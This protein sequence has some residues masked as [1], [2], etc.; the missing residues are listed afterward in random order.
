MLCGDLCRAQLLTSFSHRFLTKQRG[1]FVTLCQQLS[2]IR[3]ALLLP[4]CQLALGF[5]LVFLQQLKAL[6]QSRRFLLRTLLF[7]LQGIQ[8]ILRKLYGFGE[9]FVLQQK[10]LSG[11]L[12][13]IASLQPG[14]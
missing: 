13:T 11:L 14:G 1:A 6:I 5:L 9:P 4:L 7:S 8:G 12:F 10:L 2:F 3:Q